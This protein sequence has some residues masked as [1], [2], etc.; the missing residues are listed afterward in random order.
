ME[1]GGNG[2]GPPGGGPMAPGGGMPPGGNGGRAVKELVSKGQKKSKTTHGTRQVEVHQS[3]RGV[4]QT[5]AVLL[6]AEDQNRSLL[7]V[8]RPRSRKQL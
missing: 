3:Q 4:E 5:Q 7:E 1:P 2:G 8:D 6:D